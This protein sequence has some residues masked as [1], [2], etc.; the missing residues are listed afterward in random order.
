[1]PARAASRSQ[2][3]TS[4]GKTV[5]VPKAKRRPS[6]EG[7]LSTGADYPAVVRVSAATGGDQGDRG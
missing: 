4:T 7:V 3:V 6:G 2:R 5:R 1:M